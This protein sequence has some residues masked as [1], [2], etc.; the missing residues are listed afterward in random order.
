LTLQ[1]II[2]ILRCMFCWPCISRHACNGTNL[3]HYLSSVFFSCYPST[4]FELVSSPSSGGKNVYMR[5]LV[6]VVRLSPLLT[7]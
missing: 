1:D 3:M 7:A 6:C 2:R 4:C 5:Q